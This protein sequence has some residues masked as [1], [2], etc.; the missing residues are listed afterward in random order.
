M[1]TLLRRS[2][3][4]AATGD[5]QELQHHASVVLSVISVT[6]SLPRLGECIYHGPPDIAPCECCTVDVAQQLQPRSQS[7]CH[8]FVVLSE[9]DLGDDSV[10]LCEDLPAKMESWALAREI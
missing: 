6:D 8:A 10:N 9:C 5:A 4:L 2:V 3:S 7:R 1:G